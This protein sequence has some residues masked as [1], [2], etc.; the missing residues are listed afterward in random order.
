[1]K[2]IRGGIALA[3]VGGILFVIAASH[4]NQMADAAAVTPPA[5]PPSF[6]KVDQGIDWPDR[7]HHPLFLEV[8]GQDINGTPLVT[9]AASPIGYTPAAIKGYLGLTG[10]GTGQT[11]AI[12]VAYDDPNIA[13]DL[14]KF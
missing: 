6:V 5:G 2:L 4:S 7:V 3:I 12:V 10:T 11:I 1:M 9:S 14:A 8:Q 13:A